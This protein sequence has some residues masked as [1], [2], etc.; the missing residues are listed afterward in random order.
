LSPWKLQLEPPSVLTCT[1]RLSS[2]RNS[3]DVFPTFHRCNSRRQI[4]RALEA[5]GLAGT[6]EFIRLP[7]NYLRIAYER[8][9]ER[10]VPASRERILVKARK[11][12]AQAELHR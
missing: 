9:V 12:D 2:N 5:A 10:F 1:P 8:T 6:V 11:L 3:D 7:P 4:A